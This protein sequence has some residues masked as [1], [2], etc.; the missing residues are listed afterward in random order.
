METAIVD[1]Q[2]ADDNRGRVSRTIETIILLPVLVERVDK[3]GSLNNLDRYLG[4][5]IVFETL[6]GSVAGCQKCGSGAGIGS[7]RP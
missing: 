2:R 6:G 7:G 4:A 5:D 3:L 1:C